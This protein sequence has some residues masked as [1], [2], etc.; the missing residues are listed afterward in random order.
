MP[1]GPCEDRLNRRVEAHDHPPLADH[2]EHPGFDD[3]PSAAGD[4]MALAA[5]AFLDKPALEGP[6]GRLAV[7]GEDLRD[8]L[9][10]FP[11]DFVVAVD[12]LE[13]DALGD[14]PPD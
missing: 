5:V 2:P 11:L 1:V 7:L 3:Q 9:S 12:A 4:H 8:L 13:A 10:R 14:S 6:E